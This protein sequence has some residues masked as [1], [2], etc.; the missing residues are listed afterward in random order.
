MTTAVLAGT[1]TENS[2]AT[3][4]LTIVIRAIALKHVNAANV[5]WL[6]KKEFLISLMNGLLWACLLG[7]GTSFYFQD[8][9]LGHLIAVSTVI[10]LCTAAIAGIVTPK[11]LY[12]LK[13]DAAIAGGV[14]VTT[15]TDI[16]GFFSFLGLATIFYG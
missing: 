13:I 1:C 3:Q 11:I 6:F 14:V 7:F 8:P 9:L 2:V 10:T 4:T 5:A 16:V 12:V 15:V